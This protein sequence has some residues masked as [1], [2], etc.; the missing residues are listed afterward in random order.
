MKNR[1]PAITRRQFLR[2]SARGA[3]WFGVGSAWLAASGRVGS[4]GAAQKGANPFAY[5]LERVS[6]TDPRLIRYEQ[7]ARF[8][9]PSP[10]PR[11]LAVG[12]EDRLYIAA[13]NGVSVLDRAGAQLDE[14]ALPAP[15]R[16]VAVA[17]DGTVYAGLR[18]HVEVFDRKGQRL[19][20]WGS[21]GKKAWLTGLAVAGQDV[22]VADAGNRVVLH[23]DKSGQLAGRIGE[24]NKDR[25]IPGLIVPSPYLDVAVARDGLLRVNNPGRH[26]VE[27]YTVKGDLEF[28]WGKPGAGIEGFCGCCNPVAVALLADGRYVTCEKGLP[29]VK[30][31]SASGAFESVVVGPESLPENAR[32][33]ALKDTSDGLLG[34]L[35]AAVDS[36]GRIYVL[37]LVA[38]DVRVM[39][40]KT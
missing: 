32:A 7:V 11:R 25:H 19:A 40:A 34:G 29:R 37:D 14:I 3:G 17:T 31:Y 35:D 22:F 38:A 2:Q 15:A 1:N 28:A 18:E 8:A 21:P 6:K 24:K 13:S 20:A 26:C 4:A 27:V 23:Y 36:Q 39:K 12:P 33:G 30:I 5:D 10:A 9:S 16:C